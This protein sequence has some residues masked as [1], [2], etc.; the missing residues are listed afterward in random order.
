MYLSPVQQK[1]MLGV[2]PESFRCGVCKSLPVKDYC[3]D[4]DE[5]FFVCSCRPGTDPERTRHGEHRSYITG[6]RR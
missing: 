4:R 1:T 3:R 6:E 2:M 5:F